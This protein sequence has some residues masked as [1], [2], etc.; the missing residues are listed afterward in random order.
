MLKRSSAAALAAVLAASVLVALWSSPS[1]AETAA[2]DATA[3]L[4]GSVVPAVPASARYLGPLGAS[5]RV[6]IDI[7]LR[8]PHPDALTGYIAA[9]GDRGSPDFRHFLTAAQFGERF[10]PPAGE[11]AAVEAALESD[12]LRPG[13]PA[14]DRLLI[15]VTAAAPVIDRALHV[16]LVG[17]RLAT[18]RI[19]YS[20]LERPRLPAD[21]TPDVETVAGLNDLAQAHSLLASE[22]RPPHPPAARLTRS[23]SSGGPVPCAKAISTAETWGSYTSD[24]LARFYGMSPLYSLGDFGQ[25]VHIAVVEFE[26]DLPGDIESYK[27]CYGVHTTIDYVTVDGGSG[28]GSGTGEAALDIET[29]VGLAPRAHLD[30]YQGPPAATPSDILDVYS[31]IVNAD[32]D[33]V[34][35]SGWGTC[36][37]DILSDNDASFLSSER[38]LFEQAATQGQTIF[39]AAGDTGSTDCFGDSGTTNGAHQAVDDP[40]SQPY[41]VGVGGTTIGP[42]GERVWNDSSTQSGA[43]GGGVSAVECMPGYQMQS[44]TAGKSNTPG[45]ISSYSAAVAKTTCPMGYRREVPDVSA[46]ADPAS[47]YVIYWSSGAPGNKGPWVGGE[48]GTSAASPLWAAV[49]ALVDA[50]PFCSDYQST[51]ASSKGTLAEDATGLMF[52][53]LYYVADSP[54]Y[55]AELYDVTVGN[56]F[57][58]PSA[59]TDDVYPATVDY[60]M[61]SGLGTPS[62]AY[63]DIFFPGLAALV[64]GV[65][66]TKLTKSTISAVVPD[67]GAHTR[68]TTVEILGTGFLPIKDA[69]MVKVGSKWVTARCATTT[70]CKVTLPPS[71]S[72]TVDL[73]VSVEDLTETA[74]AAGDRFSFAARPTVTRVRPLKG[75]AR[76]QDTVTIHGSGFYEPLKVRFGSRRATDVHVYS[77][78]RMTVKAPAGTGSVYVYV[79]TV[80]GTSSRTPVGKFKYLST[81]PQP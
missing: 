32:S 73:R 43:G 79:T 65:T 63:P 17:Y 75:A 60:D 71:R 3:V 38:T 24:V 41:V 19:V 64:C 36:E 80:A 30:V 48:G 49:A 46:D 15:P 68:H 8:L 29:I 27:A 54:F 25:G 77:P 72:G 62:V 22:P 5:S 45:L 59:S 10:G 23:A 31:A 4:S 16:T 2:S 18:G 7:A 47:G 9:L 12:G 56:N 55:S 14:A 67:V 74:I 69:D 44:Q 76:G 78:G 58:T 37:P 70:A 26:P 81:S 1:P 57:Y 51:D 39:A 66:A 33:Q 52:D 42:G 40:A 6:H 20:A 53:S 11:V 28:T 35:S 21:I 34:V 13:A 50:S 61:A